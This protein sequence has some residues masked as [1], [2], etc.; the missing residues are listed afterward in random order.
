M[1][2]IG[3]NGFGR[4]GKCVFLQLIQNPHVIVKAINAPDFDIE[5]I[6]FYLK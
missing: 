6:E 5:K 3:I 2:S 1:I 4:I